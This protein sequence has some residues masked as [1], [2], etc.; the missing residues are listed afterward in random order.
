MV[1][2]RRNGERGNHIERDRVCL[3]GESLERFVGKWDCSCATAKV[4]QHG[5]R[6][7]YSTNGIAPTVLPSHT[8]PFGT[9]SQNLIF[10]NQKKPSVFLLSAHSRRED[11]N[12]SSKSNEASAPRE[13]E[14]SFSL[15]CFKTLVLIQNVH[16]L[17]N[18]KLV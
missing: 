4:P 17:F 8:Y 3:Y 9:S 1:K 2:G 5:R 18:M 7:V 15:G 13:P 6:P 12:K 10:G 11:K 14:Y 16:L